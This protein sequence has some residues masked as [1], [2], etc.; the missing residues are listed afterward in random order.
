VTTYRAIIDSARL[1]RSPVG[2]DVKRKVTYLLAF[3]ER[4]NSTPSCDLLRSESGRWPS[5]WLALWGSARCWIIDRAGP[6]GPYIVKRISEGERAA[7]QQKSAL[8]RFAQ[9][10]ARET[11]FD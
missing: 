9:P 7:F 2:E 3:N 11:S 8:Q 5:R 1:S 6:G 10:V 4:P